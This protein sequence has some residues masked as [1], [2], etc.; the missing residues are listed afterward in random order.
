VSV[1]NIHANYEQTA[2]PSM[3]VM[4]TTMTASPTSSASDDSSQARKGLNDSSSILTTGLSSQDP[5]A[6]MTMTETL[7]VTPP[8]SVV[9]STSTSSERP[10]FTGFPP[11]AKPF[12]DRAD[13]NGNGLSPTSERILIAVGA[14]GMSDAP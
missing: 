9:Q 2:L 14:I 8:L 7:M 13:R 11:G 1:T 6:V 3:S 12:R 4:T 10:R 5:V